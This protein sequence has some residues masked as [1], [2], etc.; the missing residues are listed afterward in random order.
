M[1]LLQ[2]L[3]L[4]HAAILLSILSVQYFQDGDATVFLSSLLFKL[5]SDTIA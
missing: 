2:C 3:V 5:W 4:E 1:H